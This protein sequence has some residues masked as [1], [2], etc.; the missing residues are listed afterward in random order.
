MSDSYPPNG[1]KIKVKVAQ[2][3]EKQVIFEDIDGLRYVHWMEDDARWQ[4]NEWFHL[5]DEPNL[6]ALVRVGR[7]MGPFGMKCFME[8]AFDPNPK[9]QTLPVPE[10]TRSPREV[11]KAPREQAVAVAV[12][13]DELD[14]SSLQCRFENDQAAWLRAVAKKKGV[15][16]SSIASKCVAQAMAWYGA[17]DE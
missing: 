1:T 7:S 14:F 8:A 16:C 13:D 11:Y 4:T 2:W 15:S 6:E 3:K 17:F 5:L 9:Q 10:V 12:A